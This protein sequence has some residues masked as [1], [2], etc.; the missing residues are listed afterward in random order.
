ML[1]QNY[2]ILLNCQKIAK[3][4][5]INP[6]NNEYIG[7]SA[8]RHI[9]PAVARARVLYSGAYEDVSVYGF[10]N[11]GVRDYHICADV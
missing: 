7:Y 8:V 1:S 3:F 4:A 2:E 11:S 5:E 6:K 9:G 10:C